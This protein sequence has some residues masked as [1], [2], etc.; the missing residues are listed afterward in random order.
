VEHVDDFTAPAE[1]LGAQVSQVEATV[2]QTVTAAW[3]RDAEL[4][5]VV[6]YR[7]PTAERKQ[8][9]IMVLKN[10]GWVVGSLR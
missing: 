9:Y 10:S 8:R 4:T 6:R 5:K 1:M 2:K 7:A 3:T